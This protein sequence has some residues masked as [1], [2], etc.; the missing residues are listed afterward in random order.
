MLTQLLQDLVDDLCTT[1]TGLAMWQW[2]RLRR[3]VRGQRRTG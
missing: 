2:P 3:L 1:A